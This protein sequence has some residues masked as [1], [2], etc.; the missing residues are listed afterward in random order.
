DCLRRREV[1][2]R[3]KQ[4]V[5]GVGWAGAQPLAT[6]FIFTMFL[7]RMAGASEG[8]ENY[9]LFVFAGMVPWTF[10]SN[11]ETGAANSLVAN[12]RLVTR[13]YF[14][15]IILPMCSAGAALFDFAIAAV[16]MFGLG[17]WYWEL[18]GLSVLALPLIVVLLVVAALGV[19]VLLSALIVSQRDFRYILAFGVQLCMFATPSIYL[20]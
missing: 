8:V 12:E 7:G 20:S 9:P 6:M 1:A 10:F 3:Y 18:P 5:L 19:G 14:P 13:G 16:L 4:T 15:R 11:T 2:V 17:L